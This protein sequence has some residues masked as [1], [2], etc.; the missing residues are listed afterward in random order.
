MWE[1]C[2]YR[3]GTP[4]GLSSQGSSQRA[5]HHVKLQ[6]VRRDGSPYAIRRLCL[7]QLPSFLHII[8]SLF[9]PDSGGCGSHQVSQPTSLDILPSSTSRTVLT[10]STMGPPRLHQSRYRS[11][12]RNISMN[13]PIRDKRVGA[14][15]TLP[16][17]KALDG[18]DI[19]IIRLHEHFSTTKAHTEKPNKHQF[20]ACPFYK[21]DPFDYQDCIHLKMRT[22][23]DVKQHL[24]RRHSMSEYQCRHCFHT[25]SSKSPPFNGHSGDGCQEHDFRIHKQGITTKQKK[26]LSHRG[27]KGQTVEQWEEI[28]RILFEAEPCPKDPYLGTLFDEVFGMLGDYWKHKSSPAAISFIEKAKAG[29]VNEGDIP[30]LLKRLLKEAQRHFAQ[31]CDGPDLME[32][33]TSH[34]NSNGRSHFTPI[35]EE[36]LYDSLENPPSNTGESPPDDA[37]TLTPKNHSTPKPMTQRETLTLDSELGSLAA[38]SPADLPQVD[39]GF[40]GCPASPIEYLSEFDWGPVGSDEL[41]LESLNLPSFL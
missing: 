32:H 20:F 37:L 38:D 27:P 15:V 10:P 26:F 5:R 22:P 39:G 12:Q 28:W 24:R 30:I 21:R 6:V 36:Q 19:R 41:D 17:R 23:S 7:C 31:R 16:R 11:P 9:P 14:S 33:E 4:L 18:A 25:I 29:G 1:V 13:S 35:L 3:I 8:A 40:L 2:V 34:E